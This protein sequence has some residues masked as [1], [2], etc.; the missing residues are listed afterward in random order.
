MKNPYEIMRETAKQIVK[1]YKKYFTIR[2]IDNVDGLG[3]RNITIY[4]TIKV[5]KKFW[6]YHSSQL[7]REYLSSWLVPTDRPESFGIGKYRVKITIHYAY[8]YTSN[9][10]N[11]DS[12]FV[13][14]IN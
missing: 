11:Y 1:E 14:R 10:K 9:I 4:A 12:I 5:H 2:H 6:S 3:G 8:Y 7:L 13:E